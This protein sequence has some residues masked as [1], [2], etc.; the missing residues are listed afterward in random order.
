MQEDVI[1]K[2]NIPLEQNVGERHTHTHI[3][4]ADIFRVLISF[5][6]ANKTRSFTLI[7]LLITL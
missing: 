5:G 1:V 2:S 3:T 7:C 4:R 6:G